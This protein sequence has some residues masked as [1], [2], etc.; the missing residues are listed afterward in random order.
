MKVILIAN[1]SANGKVLLAENTHHQAPPEALGFFVQQVVKK[2]NVIIGRKTF[3]VLQHF[4]GGTQ[5]VFPGVEIV[6]LSDD[7]QKDSGVKVVG[8]VKKAIRYLEE[9][10]FNEII[11]GGGTKTYNAFLEEDLITDIYFNYIPL[12]IGDGGVIGKGDELTTSFKLEEY[13]L[14]T[15]G[16]VQIHLVKT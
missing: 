3:E 15:E 2:G 8:S 5:Q 11:V 6:L 1:I 16:V 12:I 4:P 13:K 14:L 10:G 7:D 9:K